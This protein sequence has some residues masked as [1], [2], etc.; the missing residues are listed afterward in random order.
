MQQQSADV[1]EGAWLGS[2]HQARS[3]RVEVGPSQTER[4]SLKKSISR[5]VAARQGGNRPGWHEYDELQ[6]KN[7]KLKSKLRKSVGL[8]RA[9]DR[10]L[11]GL[12]KDIVTLSA[13]NAALGGGG[14]ETPKMKA[15]RE[16]LSDE[17]IDL[18]RRLTQVEAEK[19]ELTVQV[20]TNATIRPAFSLDGVFA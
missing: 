12:S 15:L 7:A 4:S 13:E 11:C 3:Q 1:H 2:R 19:Q 5:E 17:V 10:M 18:H 14:D 16:G 20:S 8:L 9:Q 6:R